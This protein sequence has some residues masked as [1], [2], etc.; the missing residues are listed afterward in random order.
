[1]MRKR[2]ALF[3]TFAAVSALAQQYTHGPDSER[4]DGVPRGTINKFTWVSH[5]GMFPGIERDYWIYV[6]A[7]YSPSKPACLM[8]FQ[9]GEGAINE[10]G[11]FRVPIVFDNLIQQGAL[12]VTIGVFIN[13]GKLPG[14]SDKSPALY[15][16]SFEYDTVDDRY[17]RF[18]TE[19]LL[20]EVSKRWNISSNPNDRGIAGVSSGGIAS[21][22]AAMLRPDA[23]HRVL[24]FIGSYANLRGGDV[25]P[26]L[27]RKM[28]PEP[29]RVFLQDGSRDLNIFGG[30]WWLSNQAMNSALNYR[31][32]EVKFVTGTEGHNGKHGG[33]ILPD[34]LRWLWEGWPAP[35]K[36]PE[37]KAPAGFADIS[38]VVDPASSWELVGED[39]GFTEGP[40]VDREGNVYFAD[41]KGN[42]IY[43]VDARTGKPAMFR[44]DTGGASGLMFGRDGRLYAA[45]NGKKRIVAYDSSGHETVLAE[46]VGS[47]DLAVSSHG[48]IYF[49][50]PSTKQIWFVDSKR[51]KRSVHRGLQ[52]P[53]GIRFTADERVL[54]VADSATRWVWSFPV[55]SDGS[56]GEGEPFYSLELPLAGNGRLV[57]AWADGMAFDTAGNLYVA[58]NSG[59]QICDQLGRVFGILRK[60]SEA[61]P[62]NVVFG[63]PDFHTLYVTVKDKVF[64]RHLL[65]GG[66]LPW[67]PPTWPPAHL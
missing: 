14:T 37:K 29:L 50:D 41:V 24:S 23:F 6:P 30:D 54:M 45:Q 16:R 25:W 42:R 48:D 1:M 61:D 4:H 59:I 17:V 31:G 10:N 60:P 57:N 63:G 35:V 33:A 62:S 43:K 52:F 20:P 12:P 55:Q 64:R 66:Y 15:N 19:E 39:Y 40:A 28:E 22:T 49:T 65:Q 44:E 47:N 67:E 38:N 51:Q 26:D 21:F 8:V 36:T 34:A 13:P 3:V 32:Y 53:N 27:V 9:D 11:D 2:F 46:S 56:L 58:T 18:L 5:G 7:Q